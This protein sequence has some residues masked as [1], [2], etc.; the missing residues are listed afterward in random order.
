MIKLKEFV[1][2]GQKINQNHRNDTL[3]VFAWGC[4][5][6]IKE[7]EERQNP[8]RSTTGIVNKD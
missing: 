2:T 8:G 6:P 1:T 4:G 3:P 7:V 5:F